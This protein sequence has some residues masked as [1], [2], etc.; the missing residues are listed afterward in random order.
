MTGRVSVEAELRRTL[1]HYWSQLPAPSGPSIS[2]TDIPIHL[3]AG[4]VRVGVDPDRH[5]HLLVPIASDAAEV[6]DRTGSGVRLTTR[7][8]TSGEGSLRYADLECARPDLSG[9]FTGLAADVCLAL[10]GGPDDPGAAVSAHL[11]D[12]RALLGPGFRAWTTPRLGGLTA[13][14][15]VLDR[16]LDLDAHAVSSWSGP[17]GEAQDFRS[18]RHAIEVKASLTKEGR[19]IRVHGTD[20]LEPPVG[21]M[22]GLMWFRL[23]SAEP[24]V[25]VGLVELIERCLERGG[26]AAVLERLDRLGFPALSEPEIAAA[27]FEVVEQRWYRVDDDF[28]AI[29]PGRFLERAVPAGVGAVEYLV[30]LDVVAAETAPVE[31]LLTIF[32]EQR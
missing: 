27:R 21:G 22:L 26:A 8:L 13:E 25:G 32:L 7:P 9:V 3:A 24:G 17:L 5:R 23:R 20:Q 30:D 10:L 31:D 18:A 2:S 4:T 14:L 29:H 12:W 28:P 15:L 1:E 6:T 16:L 19:L 11:D